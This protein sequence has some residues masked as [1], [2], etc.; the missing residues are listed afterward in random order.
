MP[1]TWHPLANI[2][3]HF[4]HSPAHETPAGPPSL[5][6]TFGLAP[7]APQSAAPGSPGPESPGQASTIAEPVPDWSPGHEKS[8]FGGFHVPNVQGLHMPHLQGLH[9]PHMQLPHVLRGKGHAAPEGAPPSAAEAAVTRDAGQSTPAATSSTAPAEQ[10][11]KPSSKPEQ[12]GAS[13]PEQ[14]GEAAQSGW[15]RITVN[16][17]HTMSG[18]GLGLKLQDRIIVGFVDEKANHFGFKKGQQ[19]QAINGVTVSNHDEFAIEMGKAMREYKAARKPMVFEVSQAS[20]VAALTA[21]ATAAAKAAKDK[22]AQGG[23][24]AKS[25]TAS[26][27][28]AML[29]AGSRQ[30]AAASTAVALPGADPASAEAPKSQSIPARPPPR[31]RNLCC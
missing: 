8:M 25:K 13:R 14:T 6:A 22:V 15:Q 18:K 21:H 30:M 2:K 4:D 1:S 20:S 3:K 5:S 19:I 12:T 31:R 24:A 10:A 26:A 16:F 27:T 9:V 7:P 29:A 11:A 17:L 23:S 28:A